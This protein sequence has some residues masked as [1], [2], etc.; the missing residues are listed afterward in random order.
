MAQ[1]DMLTLDTTYA[2]QWGTDGGWSWHSQV[3]YTDEA[4]VHELGRTAYG[5][6]VRYRVVTISR[7]VGKAVDPR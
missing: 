1:A 7:S 5:G 4:D 2:I 3:E 6:Q